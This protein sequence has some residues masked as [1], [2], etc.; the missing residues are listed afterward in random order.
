MKISD[1]SK[2][3]LKHFSLLVYTLSIFK[4]VITNLKLRGMYYQL[5]SKLCENTKIYKYAHP[6]SNKVVYGACEQES[7]QEEK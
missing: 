7:E 4:I 1:T 2:S 3:G 6:G 5:N